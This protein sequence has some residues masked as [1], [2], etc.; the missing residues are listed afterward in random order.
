MQTSDEARRCR[1]EQRRGQ[2]CFLPVLFIQIAC[3]NMMMAETVTNLE[4]TS[5]CTAA[6]SGMA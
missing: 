4:L 5:D 3:P 2:A 1:G 6:M